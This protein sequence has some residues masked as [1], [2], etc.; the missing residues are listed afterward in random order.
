MIN[1][2]RLPLPGLLMRLAVAFS[3][4]YPAV[5]AWFDPYAWIGY[6]PAFALNS[7]G[8][9]AELLLHAWGALEILLALWVLFAVRVYIPSIIMAALLMAVVIVNPAQ[10]PILFRDISIALAALSLAVVNWQKYGKK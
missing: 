6:F 8:N 9:N 4:I 3:F 1:P 5:S 10:F 7:A 2:F